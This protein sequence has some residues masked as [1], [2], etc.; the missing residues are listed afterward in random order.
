MS[1]ELKIKPY[2]QECPNFE[3][4]VMESFELDTKKRGRIVVCKSNYLCNNMERFIRNQ[5]KNE[6]IKNKE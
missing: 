4:E 6:A 2:C 1:I 3:P 5:I